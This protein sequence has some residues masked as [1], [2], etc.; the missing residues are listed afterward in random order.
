M[1][2]PKELLALG[3]DLGG[4]NARVALVSTATGVVESERIA[5][6]SLE[7]PAQFIDWLTRQTA[8][9]SRDHQ[10]VGVGIGAPN[11]HH[12]RGTIENPP[13]LPWPGVTPVVALLAEATG[14][15]VTLD[16]D[17]NAAALGEARFGAGLGHEHFAMVTLGTGIGGGVVVDGKV[18]RGADGFGGELGHLIV[19]PGGRLCGCGRRGCAETYASVRGLLATVREG[20]ERGEPGA[21]AF[22]DEAF[23]TDFEAAGRRVGEAAAAGNPLALRAYALAAEMLGRALADL[24]SITAPSRVVLFGGLVLAGDTFLGPLQRHFE[25]GLLPCHRGQIELVASSLPPGHAALLGAA[26]LAFRRAAGA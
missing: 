24:A 1:T 14:Q 19:E 9:W 2:D 3:V 4:T 18:L 7:R 23:R 22:D 26:E 6:S 20:V 13:N 10:L 12:G 25:A 8:T 5:T 21:D 16:N 11:G 15:R 17:A